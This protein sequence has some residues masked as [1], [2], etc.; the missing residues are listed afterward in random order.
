MK[1]KFFN[2]DRTASPKF[3]N[4]INISIVFNYLRKMGP[5]SRSEIAKNLKLSPPAVSRV[6]N[7]L[8]VNGYILEVGSKKTSVG[9]RPVL[10]EINNK[11]YV[12]GVDLG[13]R[14]IKIAFTNFCGHIIFEYTGFDIPSNTEVEDKNFIRDLIVLV[15]TVIKKAENKKIVEP[16]KLK[17][18]SFALSAPISLITNKI[19]DIPLYGNYRKIDFKKIFKKE[20]NVPIFIE[21]D[22]NCSAYSEKAIIKDREVKDIIFIEISRGIGSGII[23]NN[24]IFKG[25]HGTSGE[26]GNSIIDRDNLSFKI[27]N[28][29]FL[30]KYASVEG[31][32]KST[33][34]EIKKGKKTI[35]TEMVG[36][37]IED[38]EAKDIFLAALKKDNLALSIIN[39]SVDLLS[40]AILNLILIVDPQLVVL[41]GEMCILPEA[42]TL[43]L[44]PIISKISSALPFEIPKTR[45]SFAGRDAGVL[46]AALMAIETLILEEFPFKIEI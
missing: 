45:F 43:F 23:I 6:I 9:K 46:G 28:K 42:E 18:V 17:A 25:S 44:N 19:F 27:K 1:N 34:R 10:F 12:I 22:V 29:G 21:N 36:Y 2:I 32:T 13:K 4:K 7:F 39:Q 20:L 33:I 26:I 8:E 40:V 30:E 35:I 24:E 41:G 5:I 14:K 31:I 37:K 16:D 3:Q 15:K 38:I 11:S